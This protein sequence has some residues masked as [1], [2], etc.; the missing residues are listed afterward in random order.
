VSFASTA[1]KLSAAL[2]LSS[3]GAFASSN[4]CPGNSTT[5]PP[6]GSV[7]STLTGGPTYSNITLPGASTT[8]NLASLGSA[9][10]T[11]I[12]LSFSN[13][14]QT[15]SGTGENALPSAG[16]TYVSIT[17]AGTVATTPDTL[18]FSTIQGD[19]S[20]STD[21]QLNDGVLNTKVDGTE[22]LTS[23]ISYGVTNS[24][25]TGIYAVVLSVNGITIAAGGSG[26]VTI[27]TCLQ[28]NGVDQ[29][30]GNITN[31]VECKIA[32]GGGM[33]AGIFQSSTITLAQLVSQSTTINLAMNST[34]AD[35]TQVIH[36][37]CSSCGT[38]ETGF[39]TFSDQFQESPEPSTFILIGTGLGAAALVR[40]RRCKKA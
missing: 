11:A 17:P 19:A 6:P 9:G 29:P 5:G 35:I 23:T 38:N 1:M 39:L 24:A 15:S 20:N 22:S 18:L 21:G 14:T 13:F 37:S 27:D 32:A 10:C 33:G 28:G 3:L 2:L 8:N 16:G 31:A 30:T 40:F 26:T 34:Y 36:L 4:N 25:P 7:T 12:D